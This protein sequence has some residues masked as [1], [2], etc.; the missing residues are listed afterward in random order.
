[1]MFYAAWLLTV[2]CPMVFGLGRPRRQ[3]G[4]ALAGTAVG[5]VAG[6]ILVLTGRMLDQ[7]SL[8]GAVVVLAVLR[9]AR[10]DAVE[11]G[12]LGSAVL[13]LQ[14]SALLVSYGVPVWAALVL[15]G[16]AALLPA[17]LYYRSARFAPPSVQEEALLLALALGL[18]LGAAPEVESGW[19]SAL[20]LNTTVRAADI[21]HPIPHWVW[22]S[23]AAAAVVGMAS[24]W[25]RR[26]S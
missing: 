1:M 10:P 16:V 23:L 14:G 26:G 20:I 18:V 19:R 12:R 7:T 4:W 13:A 17:W 3:P 11:I 25:W 15:G 9:L 22:L 5:I 2:F 21:A 6:V 24:R 8:G